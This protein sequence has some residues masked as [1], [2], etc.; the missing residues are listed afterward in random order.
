MAPGTGEAEQRAAEVDPTVG[1]GQ[2]GLSGPNDAIWAQMA[3]EIILEADMGHIESLAEIVMKEGEA[4]QGAIHEESGLR[5]NMN[6]AQLDN[7]TTPGSGT[8]S[9]RRRKKDRGFNMSPNLQ[10][11][12]L[13]YFN[14]SNSEHDLEIGLNEWI[15]E[16]K[17][18]MGQDEEFCSMIDK[19]QLEVENFFDKALK[20]WGRPRMELVHKATSY[21]LSKVE[22]FEN[23]KKEK[24]RIQQKFKIGKWVDELK[25][26][27]GME[28]IMEALKEIKSYMS[29]VYD[30][31]QK[32]TAESDQ[33]DGE[34]IEDQME[35]NFQKSVRDLRTQ[36]AEVMKSAKTEGRLP[37]VD[38]IPEKY[39]EGLMK[40]DLNV[41]SEKDFPAMA[42]GVSFAKEAEV[43]GD[44]DPPIAKDPAHQ[45]SIPQ[46]NQ[47]TKGGNPKTQSA[48]DNAQKGKNVAGDGVPGYAPKGGNSGF[49]KPNGGEKQAWGQRGSYSGRFTTGNIGNPGRNTAG[50]GEGRRGRS[51]V[52]GGG[53]RVRSSSGG[54]QQQERG[55]EPVRNREGKDKNNEG[56]GKNNKGK[57]VQEEGEGEFQYQQVGYGRK[58]GRG[59]RGSDRGRG[60]GK[61]D[62]GGRGDP[63]KGWQ[64]N[65]YDTGQG[66]GVEKEVEGI[67]ITKNGAEVS[68]SVS[69]G[70]GTEQ[71]A[72]KA[73]MEMD[74][75]KD[76]T[77]L[78]LS[79]KKPPD[80][81]PSKPPDKPPGKQKQQKQQDKPKRVTRSQSKGDPVGGGT[82]LGMICL[83]GC[84]LGWSIGDYYRSFEGFNPAWLAHGEADAEW[85]Q[86]FVGIREVGIEQEEE[87]REHVAPAI[88]ERRGTPPVC[89]N[90]SGR[91]NAVEEAE[92]VQ[93][94][95][96]T[97]NKALNMNNGTPTRNTD[98]LNKNKAM[99]TICANTQ[100]LE[101]GNESVEEAKQCENANEKLGSKQCAECDE[102]GEAKYGE[103]VDSEKEKQGDS[104]SND[105]SKDESTQSVSYGTWAENLKKKAG[106]DSDLIKVIEE[107]KQEVD[108]FFQL[109]FKELGKEIYDEC[110]DEIVKKANEFFILKLERE[111]KEIGSRL[112]KELGWIE[113]DTPT[114]KR[115]ENGESDES[116]NAS[117]KRK[118]RVIKNSKDWVDIVKE[119]MEKDNGFERKVKEALKAVND[120]LWT[121]FDKEKNAYLEDGKARAV[122][123]AAIF[124]EIVKQSPAWGSE[125]DL[126][127]RVLK[128]NQEL[129]GGQL[130]IWAEE[131]NLY[132]LDLA[133][134]RSLFECSDIIDE[135]QESE[136]DDSAAV[137]DAV[138]EFWSDDVEIKELHVIMEKEFSCCDAVVELL[139]SGIWGKLCIG[140]GPYGLK[141]R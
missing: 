99:P 21:L 133:T 84:G 12:G 31:N 101:T 44:G 20:E 72:K 75:A 120:Y 63:R 138:L 33:R 60:G 129:I 69:E 26:V 124:L 62:G 104:S 102:N 136:F 1:P 22:G 93:T 24:A 58:Y 88:A 121:V 32:V 109:A 79:P 66:S 35:R 40:K 97:T 65:L 87:D 47:P 112:K 37:L 39:V 139:E 18:K 30:R 86:S 25:E 78:N 92:Q 100:V 82:P 13:D 14:N 34:A 83:Y 16:V 73:E 114:T 7:P 46:V 91:P 59:G 125:N 98:D 89:G 8:K 42:K 54:R 127:G 38:G 49:S 96:E 64:Y 29:V 57:D 27:V 94:G 95:T 131:W 128:P 6:E 50:V 110:S 130:C 51:W 123:G 137:C 70:S 140:P 108:R 135:V 90:V 9:I 116:S 61:G 23:K 4:G 10:V 53:V 45:Q 67:P 17:R 19:A 48:S 28:L 85:V 122:R 126:L 15:E 117:S 113:K 141:P 52:R 81:P 111:G 71:L 107:A 132:D 134:A 55:R 41:G 106:E 103:E 43:L 77:Q 80:K 105:G 2:A 119:F 3:D 56:M 74:M 11:A 76:L 36:H 5:S 68:L 118:G 115:N